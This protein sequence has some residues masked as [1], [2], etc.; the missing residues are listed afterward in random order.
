M[1]VIAMPREM[2]TLGK[3]VAFGVAERLGL[4]AVHRELVEL[5]VAARMNV[6]Q[7]AVH[8]F[9]EGRPSLWERWQ[10]D[11]NKLAQFTAE[12]MLERAAKGNVVIR[13]WG[14]VTLLR[15]IPHVLCV[16]VCAP[17]AF[18]VR[19][20]VDRLGMD[21]EV[22]HREIINNDKAHLR[23]AQSRNVFD[24]TN[25]TN[26]DLVL[27]TERV[28]IADCIDRVVELATCDAFTETPASNRILADLLMETRIRNKLS[29]REHGSIMSHGLEVFAADGEVTISGAVYDKA[30]ADQAYLVAATVDGV[31]HVERRI[32]IVPTSYLGG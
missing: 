8:Q 4:E 6:G 7:L 3:E 31:K 29:L 17:M 10:I 13:G 28:P 1:T 16:R 22:A 26:F 11:P 27:N 23:S 5:E 18:R 24:W 15:R 19:E 21:A 25:S 20:M 14:A 32:T 12:E 2:G 30:L 9:L